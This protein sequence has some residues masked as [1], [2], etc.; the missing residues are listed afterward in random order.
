VLEFI[1][2]GGVG[3]IAGAAEVF[4]VEADGAAAVGLAAPAAPAGTPAD[5]TVA[6][7]LFGDV[8]VAPLAAVTGSFGTTSLS[9]CITPAA[10]TATR[11]SLRAG[12]ELMVC[13]HTPRGPL[14]DFG[15]ERG[16]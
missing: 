14:F 9:G 8:G 12:V 13:H 6:A 16:D 2:P 11:L 3:G 7:A 4:A 15:D 10:F 5:P 1:I